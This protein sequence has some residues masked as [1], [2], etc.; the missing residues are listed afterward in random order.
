MHASISRFRFKVAVRSPRA[1]A[2][3]ILTTF[4]LGPLVS[5]LRGQAPAAD[6]EGDRV[7]VTSKLDEDR[8]QIVPSLGATEYRIGDHQIGE[9]SQ[10]ANASFNQVLL[11][12]PGVV[13]D[14]FGQLHVRGEHANLQYRINDVLL[15]EGIAG[16]GQ[17]LDTRFIQSLSLITGSLPAQYGFRTAGIIDIQT[18]NGAERID[19]EVSLYGGSRATIK[20]SLQFGGGSG[21]WNYYFTGSYLQSDLGI[22]NPT[23][24]VRAIHDHTEQDKLFCYASYLIDATS[25]ISLFASASS[26]RFQIPNTPG[27]MPA[28]QLS[29][30]PTFDSAKLDETQAE[31][32]AYAIIAYQKSVGALSLQLALFTRY[33]RTTYNPDIAGDL[34]FNGVAGQVGRSLFSSG[35]QADASYVLNAQNTLRTGLITTV[36]RAS[37]RSSVA[38]FPTDSDGNQAS[39][40]PFSIAD[41]YQ[42]T[43]LLFGLYLQ[44]EWKPIPKLTVNFGLRYDLSSAYVFESQVDPRIN[45]VYEFSPA[46]SLHAGY[47]RYFTPPPLELVN[48]ATLAKFANTTNSP[49]N[50]ANS[51]VRSESAHY[52]DLGINTKPLPGLQFG[53]DAY[54]KSARNQLDDGQFGQALILSPFN[55]AYG[56]IYGVEFSAT[57]AY[58]GFAAYAN[59]AVNRAQGKR[60]TSGQFEF[61]R[62]ELS[63][64]A[65]H[66]VSLDHDQTYT[67]SAGVS[68]QWRNTMFLVDLLYGSGLRRGFANT[69]HLPAYYPVNLGIVQ[70]FSIPKLGRFKARFDLV[71]VFDQVYQLRDG[72]GIGVGAAQYGPRRGYF[73]GLAFEF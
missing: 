16:F 34:I 19:N 54:Y 18:K 66:W 51:N 4:L 52:F 43:G 32:N 13:Q 69:G 38:V 28:F 40:T 72:S 26:S 1:P 36:N 50:F 73:G 31:Q 27:L 10:G 24:S 53:M 71:N 37:V 58:Q 70:S 14:S 59:F 33:S 56:R 5:D 55:Y 9:Q 46:I 64:I 6:S 63:Y 68:Y 57:Y 7:V 39:A 23:A 61:G 30:I 42:K 12:A 20:P 2:A 49:E 8:N 35:F 45:L 15:P 62:D 3:L 60:I 11:R 48:R 41:A 67:A 29:G 47:A 25:R 21:K 17:E 22:E 44:D 65:N